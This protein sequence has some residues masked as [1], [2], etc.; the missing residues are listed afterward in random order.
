VPWLGARSDLVEMVCDTREGSH[1]SSLS[2][3]SPRLRRP[4]LGAHGRCG[5]T[6]PFVTVITGGSIMRSSPRKSAKRRGSGA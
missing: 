4:A 1:C 3:C 2:P 5:V 6:S